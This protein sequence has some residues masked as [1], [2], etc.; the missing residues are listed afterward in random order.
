MPSLQWVLGASW[1]WVFPI[2][3]VAS[4]TWSE[5]L[6]P[7]GPL[8]PISV[9]ALLFSSVELC[10]HTSHYIPHMVYSP[11]S[12][13]TTNI[14][15]PGFLKLN[16]DPLGARQKQKGKLPEKQRWPQERPDVTQEPTTTYKGNPQPQGS[17]QTQDGEIHCGLPGVPKDQSWELLVHPPRLAHVYWNL[18]M[19]S[20]S[21][22]VPCLKSSGSIQWGTGS[23]G[24][25]LSSCLSSSWWPKLHCERWKRPHSEGSG[26]I[27]KVSP[28]VC[29]TW[30]IT[31]PLHPHF[32]TLW[33]AARVPPSWSHHDKEIR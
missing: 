12:S 13:S 2:Y 19:A 7:N 31:S 24:T 22:A 33:R 8:L 26:C 25:A 10:S 18:P 29:V 3:Q 32:I 15:E 28:L 20:Q 6:A 16:S 1:L 4:R 23:S 5:D 21:K 27:H 9:S 30:S 11:P 14:E 17:S